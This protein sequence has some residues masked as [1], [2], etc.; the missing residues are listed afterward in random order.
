MERRDR[1]GN[2]KQKRERWKGRIRE[3]KKSGRKIE[4][5]KEKERGK[6]DRKHKKREE[7][8]EE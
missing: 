2:R 8:K 4:G 3:V 5:T 1:K 6:K 7:A